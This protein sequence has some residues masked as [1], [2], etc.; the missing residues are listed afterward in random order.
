MNNSHCII[1]EN[2]I[3]E[4]SA[5]ILTFI[6]SKFLVDGGLSEWSA[7]GTCSKDCGTGTTARTRTCTNPSPQN[8]GKDC[9]DLGD[10]EQTEVCNTL[11]CPGKVHSSRF[12][13]LTVRE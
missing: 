12:S 11:K 10:K 2:E 1:S 7:W 9:T 3:H 13:S 8:G 5:S 4:E 6:S